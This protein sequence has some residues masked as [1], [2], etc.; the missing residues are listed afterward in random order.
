MAGGKWISDLE[1]TTPIADAARHVLTV[2]LEGVRD[3][4]PLALYESDRDPEHVHQV[5]V[6]TRRAGAALDIFDCCLPR[7]VHVGTRKHLRKIRRG[8]GEARDWDVLLATLIERCREQGRKPR[9]GLDCLVGYVVAKREAAQRQLELAG[10]D[11]PFAFDRLLAETVAAVHKPND[12]SRRC[13]LDLARPLLTAALAELDHAVGENLEAYEQLHQVRICGKRLRYAM[14]IFAACFASQFREHFYRAVEEMQEVLGRANDSYVACERLKALSQRLQALAPT[15]W[16]R[17]R[18]G[19][20]SQLYYHQARLPQERQRFQ[21]WWQRW[22]RSGGEAALFAFLESSQ[23]SEGG[24]GP[25]LLV[26]PAPG[27]PPAA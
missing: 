21:E 20:E 4:L 1:A 3:C 5:R 9:A 23:N 8:A 11:Y 26:Y 25:P 6:A 18:P 7:K 27:E 24:G 12:S 15:E 13:L 17:Y 19:L 16:R 22:R 14:E 2:R 10:A